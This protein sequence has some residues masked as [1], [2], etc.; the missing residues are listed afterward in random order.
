[1]ALV[2]AATAA[3]ISSGVNDIARYHD[4]LHVATLTG[5]KYFDAKPHEFR[6]VPGTENKGVFGLLP[7]GES[8]LAAAGTAGLFE[9]SGKSAK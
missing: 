1:M 3:G 9:V 6:D 2:Q 5:L 4:I 8:L 7:H